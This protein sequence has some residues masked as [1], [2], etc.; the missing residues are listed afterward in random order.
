MICLSFGL[1]VSVCLFIDLPKWLRRLRCCLGVDSC[2]GKNHVLGGGLHHPT[3]RGTFGGT[4]IDMP[5]H[6]QWL[7]QS[8]IRSLVANVSDVT[9]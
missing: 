5:V 6:A 1:S 8:V 9:L 3:G 4:Y 2:G 7:I